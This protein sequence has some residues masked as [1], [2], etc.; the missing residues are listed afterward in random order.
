VAGP[1]TVPARVDVRELVRVVDGTTGTDLTW[2]DLM[3]RLAEHDIVMVGERHDDAVGHAV[4]LAIVEDMIADRGP[5]TLSVEMLERDEQSLVSDYFD[6]IID[7]ETFEDL[8]NSSGWGGGDGSWKGW[9]Q[10]MIDAVRD[11][12]GM[13]VAAN[14]PR[15]YVRI[16]RTRG[17]DALRALDPDRRALF[18][19]PDTSFDDYRA[20]FRETMDAMR[21]EAGSGPGDPAVLDSMF[22]SQLVWDATMGGSVA[23]AWYA[24]ATPIVHLAGAFHVEQSGATTQIVRTRTGARVAVVT[25]IAGA[26]AFSPED[27]GRADF[28]V[29]TGR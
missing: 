29:Y 12:G 13:V 26:G 15:R 19:L 7:Q 5:L 20:R 17:Y 6:E 16:A 21:A 27:A 14:A 4:E 2:S 18:E 25:M 22:R 1:T 9:Y 11:A 10:P 3:S 23:R 28:I 24:G 8:T